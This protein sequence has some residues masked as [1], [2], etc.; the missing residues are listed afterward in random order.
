M[1]HRIGDRHRTTGP[2]SWTVVLVSCVFAPE[3]TALGQSEVEQPA[4]E[5]RIEAGRLVSE[6]DPSIELEV[7]EDAAYLGAKRIV[8]DDTFDAELHVFA[9]VDD[10]D[11]IQRF[12]WIQFESYLPSAPGGH[13]DYRE[14]NP[15]TILFDGIEMHVQPG[16]FQTSRETVRAGSDYEAFRTIVDEAG[17]R[18]PEWVTILRLAYLFE[19]TERKEF[20]VVYGEGPDA[21][22][23]AAHRA[24]RA[25][26]PGVLFDDLLITLIEDVDARVHVRLR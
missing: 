8:I 1:A 22:A 17:Y 7:P 26:E 21:L 15:E 6:S 23:E 16:G 10:Y 4:P 24:A 20:L 13:Y 18:L 3:R 25:G 19:P 11:L 12:Y 9:E 2:L 14:S 5:R